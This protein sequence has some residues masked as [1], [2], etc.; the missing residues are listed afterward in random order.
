VLSGILNGVD[1]SE[2][3]TSDNPFVRFPFDAAHPDNKVLNKQA[4]QDELDLAIEPETPLFGNITRLVDQKGVDYLLPALEN[5]LERNVQFV[6]LGSGDPKWENAFLDLAR[7]HPGKVAIRIGYDHALSHRIEAASDFYVM[8]SRF[9]PCGLNQMYSLRYGSIP[10]VRRTGG[11]DDSVT[12]LLENAEL[13]NG[14]KFDAPHPEPLGKALNKAL[15]L[16]AEKP[17]LRHYRHNAMT[18][19]F[20]WSRTAKEYG[21][22]YRRL[23]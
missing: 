23:V 21:R 20:S 10:I 19:D 6:L 14:I 15:H 12:D 4:L 2:W 17:L 13:A 18:A 8:P 22:I 7:R 9:E 5:V 1:Y 11:L 16:Y 3:N